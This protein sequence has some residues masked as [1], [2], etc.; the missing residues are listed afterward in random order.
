MGI[1]AA[2][3]HY[4]DVIEGLTPA[5][6]GPRFTCIERAGEGAG[7]DLDSKRHRS[8]L[9]QIYPALPRD[10]K[11][12]RFA[13]GKVRGR[14]VLRVVYDAAVPL[15]ERR[16]MQAE[17]LHTLMAAMANPT[18]YLAGTTDTINPLEE[19]PDPEEITGDGGDVVAE[20]MVIEF[21]HIYRET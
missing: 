2:V 1:R 8:R 19:Q 5:S 15:T 12:A 20:V 3:A 10:G 11:Q 9:F 13:V 7:G 21:D 6:G 18:N 4:W 16:V 14:L 17:D